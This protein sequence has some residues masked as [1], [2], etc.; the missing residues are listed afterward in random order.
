MDDVL[1]FCAGYR[2][3][4]TQFKE[5]LNLCTLATGIEINFNKPSLIHNGLDEELGGYMRDLFP[6]NSSE[7][8]DGLKYLAYMLK[9]NGYVK[10]DWIWLISNIKKESSSVEPGGCLEVAS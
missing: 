3:G 6:F 1:L 5:I 9:P 8:N 10:Q 2:E 4:E 7:F